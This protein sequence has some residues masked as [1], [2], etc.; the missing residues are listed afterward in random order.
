MAEPTR[1][2]TMPQDIRYATEP[3]DHEKLLEK[4]NDYQISDVNACFIRFLIDRR[5][6][7]HLLGSNEGEFIDSKYIKNSEYDELFF[8]LDN[9][10][11]NLQTVA[12]KFDVNLSVSCISSRHQWE[13]KRSNCPHFLSS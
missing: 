9:E 8:S 11:E 5:Q 12:K 4:F 2:M 1:R 13:T 6:K 10:Q 7:K 3:S